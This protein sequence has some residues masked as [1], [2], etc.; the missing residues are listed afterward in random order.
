MGD[1]GSK[2]F[3]SMNVIMPSPSLPIVTDT[4][5]NAKW[6]GSPIVAVVTDEQ[7]VSTQWATSRKPTDEPVYAIRPSPSAPIATDVKGW[8]WQLLRSTVAADVQSRFS[9]WATFSWWKAA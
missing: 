1:L 3:G 7:A 2:P 4:S 6:S 9:Q 5:S 8:H